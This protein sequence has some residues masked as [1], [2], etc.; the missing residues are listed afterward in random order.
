MVYGGG[1]L[2]RKEA[3]QSS[4]VSHE[5]LQQPSALDYTP[6]H[7]GTEA[8]HSTA[9]WRT[10]FSACHCRFLGKDKLTVTGGDVWQVLRKSTWTSTQV[11]WHG[12][13]DAIP[14]FSVTLPSWAIRM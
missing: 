7:M 11:H 2:P 6:S 1:V 4:K 12:R 8:E 9:I 5:F 3:S 13:T 14:G 10:V